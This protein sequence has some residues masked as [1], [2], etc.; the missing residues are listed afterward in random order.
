LKNAHHIGTSIYRDSFPNP[1][2][3]R[4][5]FRA[6]H[7]WLNPNIESCDYEIFLI[8]IYVIVIYVLI[9]DHVWQDSE[10]QQSG[11]SELRVYDIY[12]IH[13]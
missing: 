4:D 10:N 12:D 1:T 7:T 13:V 9:A 8:V 3:C 11:Y 2:T 6:M 5:R